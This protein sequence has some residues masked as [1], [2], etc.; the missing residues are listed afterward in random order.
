LLDG[1]NRLDAMELVGISFELSLNKDYGWLLNSNYTGSNT[2][3]VDVHSG[4]PY[5]YVI[6]ANIHRRHLTNEQKRDLI[7]N[8]LKA[9]PEKSNRQIA[10]LTKA[11][12]KTVGAV[13]SEK[14]GRGEIPHVKKRADTKGRKQPA[15]KKPRNAAPQV[16]A[17]DRNDIGPNSHSEIERKLARGRQLE[18]EV[19]RLERENIALKNEIEELK[20]RRIPKLAT[21]GGK[22]LLACSFC[23]KGEGQVTLIDGADTGANICICNECVERCVSIFIAEQ[24]RKQQA[25]PPPRDDGLGIPEFLRRAPAEPAS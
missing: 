15:E 16:S 12:H 22:T 6:S 2:E 5:D 1:R 25:P 7:G 9:D 24:Q 20:T 17:I 13:R 23:T 8:L 4:D 19:H 18:A 10:K 11:D 21:K 3:I 14:E